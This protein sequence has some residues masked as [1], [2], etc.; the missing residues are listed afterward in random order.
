MKA[1]HPTHW[2]HSLDLCLRFDIADRDAIPVD[3]EMDV[4]R[5][6]RYLDDVAAF[7]HQSAARDTAALATPVRVSLLGAD[8]FFQPAALDRIVGAAHAHAMVVEVWTT[9]AWAVDA[10]T[11][12]TQLAR[13]AKGADALQIY[14]TRTLLDQIGLDRIDWVVAE[15][16]RAQLGVS[17]RYAIAPDAPLAREIAAL[18]TFNADTGFLHVTPLARVIEG[19]AVLDPATPFLLTQPPAGRRCADLFALFVAPDGAVYP[20]ARGV[21]ARALRLGSLETQ[22]VGDIV[23]AALAREDLERLRHDGPLPFY[24]AAQASSAAH[25][26]SRGY[27]DSCHFHTHLLSDAELAAVAGIGEPHPKRV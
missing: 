13:F 12:H 1:L 16:R 25:R 5:A 11:V 14:T 19:A 18:E 8:A 6:C 22:S 21:G 4:S 23:R 27:V 15:A 7:V 24:R 17:L 26:L 20:C 10:D 9:A 3:W 2:F